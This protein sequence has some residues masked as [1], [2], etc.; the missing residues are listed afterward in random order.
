MDVIFSWSIQIAGL[1]TLQPK[2]I[3]YLYTTIACIHMEVWPPQ[4]WPH[5]GAGFP[6]IAISY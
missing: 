5:L 3:E 1:P 6:A 4:V 2:K